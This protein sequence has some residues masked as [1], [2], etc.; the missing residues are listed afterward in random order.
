[1]ASLCK[2]CCDVVLVC[3]VRDC[4]RL[5]VDVVDV[6]AVEVT[7]SPLCSSLGEE[8]L[9]EEEGM[10]EEVASSSWLPTVVSSLSALQNM[11]RADRAGGQIGQGRPGAGRGR[12][13]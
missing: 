5:D 4:L 13:C 8:G 10:G 12:C 2:L 9:V 3:R 11:K 7:R 1:M 6:V